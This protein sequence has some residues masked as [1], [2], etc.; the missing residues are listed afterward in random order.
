MRIVAP[1]GNID[2]FYAAIKATADE[3][4]LGLKGFGARRNAENFTVEEIKKALD[5]AHLRGSR[6]FLTLNTV[7]S[8]R[9]IESLYPILKELYNYGLDAVIV[10]DLGYAKYLYENFPKLE[11][12]GSTQLTV[13]NHYEINYLKTLGF[14]RV[15]LPRELSFEEIKT[16]RENTDIELEV[17]VSGALCISFSGNCYLSSFIGGRS[18]NRGLCAQPCRKE[19]RDSCGSTSHFLSPKDQLL[20]FNEI[21]KLKEIGIESIKIEGRMKDE[22]Y[23]YETVNYYRNLINGL[24]SEENTS[25]IFNRGYSKGYF[26]GN[27]KEIMNRLYS[28]N[29]GEKIGEVVGNSV[30]LSQDII[31]GDGITFL[32]SNYKNLGGEFINKL[33]IDGDNKGRKIAYS[34]EKISLNLPRGQLLA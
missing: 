28:H 2:R 27:N 19:Y 26:Y 13:A 6:I 32:S 3:V 34:G 12:H 4:Y 11:I 9:E 16:I 23:V 31:C 7:M 33:V 10:Q 24:D 17:F 20:G 8:N 14:K 21:K 1:A 18:G 5:Y 30:K 15:V 22:T 25:K 29:I